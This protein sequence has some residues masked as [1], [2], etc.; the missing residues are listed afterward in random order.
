MDTFVVKLDGNVVAS[1]QGDGISFGQRGGEDDHKL[2]KLERDGR[3]LFVLACSTQ[4]QVTVE[5]TDG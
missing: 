1:I 5:R 3:S 2:L 4:Q